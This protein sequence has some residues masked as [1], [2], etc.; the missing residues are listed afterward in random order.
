MSDARTGLREPWRHPWLRRC[1][2]LAVL[3]GPAACGFQLRGAAEIP[4]RFNP[5]FIEAQNGASV[6]QALLQRLEGSPVRQAASAQEARAVVRVLSESRRSRVAAVDRDNKVI[7]TELFLD[8]R[9]DARDAAGT[10]LLAVQSL[11]LSRTYENPDV[12]VLGKELEADLIYDDLAQD[13][14]EQILDRLRAVLDESA[15]GTDAPGNPNSD[16]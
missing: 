13:A 11:S 12:E 4:E 9:F 3:A 7:A 2:L 1:A 16:S 5:L 6:R 8:L 10:P 15:T 14:A